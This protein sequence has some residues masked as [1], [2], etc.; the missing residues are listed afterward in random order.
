MSCHEVDC[1]QQRSVRRSLRAVTSC[2]S[3]VSLH[4]AQPQLRAALLG[5]SIGIAWGVMRGGE[6]RAPRELINSTGQG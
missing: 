1:A 3:L 2:S 6:G 4:T 5:G